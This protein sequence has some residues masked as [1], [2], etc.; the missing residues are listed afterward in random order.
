MSFYTQAAA[1]GFP[2]AGTV[3]K[4]EQDCAAATRPQQV[5]PATPCA[6]LVVNV[7]SALEITPTDGFGPHHFCATAYYPGELQDDIEARKTAAVKAL[8]S[9]AHSGMENCV[10]H[11]QVMVPYNSRQQLLMIEIYEADQLGDS[12]IGQVTVPLAD[13]KLESTS[14]WPLI[15]DSSP[16]GVLTLNVRL[17]GSD[18]AAEPSPDSCQQRETSTESLRM[19]AAPIPALGVPAPSGAGL[20]PASTFNADGAFAACEF[21]DQGYT[22]H[23]SANNRIAGGSYPEGICTDGAFLERAFMHRGSANHGS[24]DA[25]YP[26]G[27]HTDSGCTRPTPTAPCHPHD[28]N[29]TA[30]SLLER[31]E[32]PLRAP[33]PVGPN[34]PEACA[35][36]EQAHLGGSPVHQGE[37]G[38]FTGRANSCIPAAAGALGAAAGREPFS[39]GQFGRGSIS[40]S[41]PATSV[42]G[43]GAMQQGVGSLHEGWPSPPK[44]SSGAPQQGAFP[45]RVLSTA[46]QPAYATPAAAYKVPTPLSCSRHPV[47]AAAAPPA[48]MPAHLASPKLALGRVHSYLPSP[49]RLGMQMRTPSLNAPRYAPTCA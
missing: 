19:A 12:F 46:T 21:L 6:N 30:A 42:P 4:Q 45:S 3:V 33:E 31:A 47:A 20:G 27:L 48:A 2:R 34:P 40:Y 7:D 1:R 49:M 44:L 11:K 36:P 32:Q 26:E 9:T 15:R 17:P 18:V 38:G 37:S 13:P 5:A 24:L 39:S 43:P 28:T 22:H 23:D 29:A 35:A 41:P 14:P 10:F 16:N 8:R 25:P